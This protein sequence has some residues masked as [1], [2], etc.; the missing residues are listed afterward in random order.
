MYWIVTAMNAITTRAAES[1]TAMQVPGFVRKADELAAS[2]RAAA[3]F[4][5]WVNTSDGDRP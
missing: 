3:M 2:I 1:I 4:S 5:P